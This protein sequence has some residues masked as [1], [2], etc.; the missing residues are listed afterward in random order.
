MKTL[1]FHLQLQSARGWR[2]SEIVY[3]RTPAELL[4]GILDAVAL[5]RGRDGYLADR[6]GPLALDVQREPS[7]NDL[8]RWVAATTWTLAGTLEEIGEDADQHAADWFAAAAA[9]PG[10]IDYGPDDVPF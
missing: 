9:I 2:D 5:I 3:A 10:V 6:S 7:S 1:T 4:C 8:R